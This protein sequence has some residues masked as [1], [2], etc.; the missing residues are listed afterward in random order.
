MWVYV[1]SSLLL[2]PKT[3]RAELFI[4]YVL[5]HFGVY[6]CLSVS[7]GGT[8]E[9]PTP[10]SFNML[11]SLG[12][13][14]VRFGRLLHFEGVPYIDRFRIESTCSQ[15]HGDQEHEILMKK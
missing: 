11:V 9:L 7:G 15:Q 10:D 5:S 1:D 2:Y 6:R 3:S 14:R 12:R 8:R 13:F 4:A